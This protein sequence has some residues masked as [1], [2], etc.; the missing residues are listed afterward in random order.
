M[1][2][3]STKSLDQLPPRKEAEHPIIDG[4]QN[5]GKKVDLEQLAYEN[6]KPFLPSF[7]SGKI[8][9]VYD[10][11]T[12]WIATYCD[13]VPARFRLR[14][15][16]VDTPEIKSKDPQIKAK[17]IFARDQ[18]RARILNRVVQVEILPE[19]E[20]FGRLLAR[21]SDSTGSIN[22]WLISSGMAKP[23][24]GGTKESFEE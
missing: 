6:T 23:Y 12:F 5:E 19:I 17:A 18:I 22:D 16:G 9:K 11:D 7:T 21:V 4:K 24:F 1:G 13:G 10:A 15:A 20:K 3:I 2:C 14:L 8:V